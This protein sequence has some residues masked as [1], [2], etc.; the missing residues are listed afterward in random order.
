MS[1]YTDAT[2]LKKLF[3][4]N[5][6]FKPASL[7]DHENRP[8]PK[9]EE[10]YHIFAFHNGGSDHYTDNYTDAVRIAK[11]M[12]RDGEDR[13]RIYVE[14]YDPSTDSESNEE[15]IWCGGLE[16]D[17]SDDGNYTR[18]QADEDVKNG[19]VNEDNNLFKPASEEDLVGR[20]KP[21]P[22]FKVGDKVADG[23]G[24][25]GVVLKWEIGEGQDDDEY[26]LG[27][28]EILVTD[29]CGEKTNYTIEDQLDNGDWNKL[30]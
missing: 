13:V 26:A 12:V 2:I 30:Q 25:S 4:D 28:L 1:L 9:L 20:P 11:N 3:E 15:L 7:E 10:T 17:G 19:M 14:D 24:K 21:E 5:N 23:R 8:K 22:P 16:D 29:D 6:L 27:Y 18:A